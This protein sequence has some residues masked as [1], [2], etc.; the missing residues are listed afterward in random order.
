MS[1]F[2]ALRGMD[3]ARQRRVALAA[4]LGAVA[5]SMLAILFWS[6][7]EWFYADDWTYFVSRRSWDFHTLF[8]P[9]VGHLIVLPLVLFKVLL[10]IFGATSAVPF[11][12]AALLFV[13]LNGVLVYLLARRRLDPWLALVPAVLMLLLG[14]GWEMIIAPFALNALMSI[15]AGLGMLLFLDRGDRAGD[16]GACLLLIASLA[17]FSLGIVFGVIA[18]VELWQRPGW[19]RRQGWVY[20]L[21]AAVYGV[22]LIWASQ[23]HQNQLAATNIGPGPTAVAQGA[24]AVASSAF[25]VFRFPGPANPAAPDLGIQIDWGIPIAL[26]L[27][28]VLVLRLRAA[29]PPT[30]RAWAL[31]VA[32]LVLWGLLALSI[33]PAR[34]PVASRYVYPGVLLA[35]LLAIELAAPLA[36]STGWRI[37]IAAA[38]GIS[39]LAN[40]D[41]IRV[42]GGYFRAEAGY[43]RSELAAL[44]LARGRVSDDFVVE[45][46]S[47]NL[48]PH[49]DMLFSA[50]DYF[51]AVDQYGSPA[52]SLSQLAAASPEQRAAADQELARALELAARPTRSPVLKAA[53]PGQVQPLAESPIDLGSGAN[54]AIKTPKPG[55]ALLQPIAGQSARV[56]LRLPPQ[57]FRYGVGRDAEMKLAL[58]RFGDGF[59][60]KLAPVIGPAVV[61]IPKDGSRRPWH[62]LIRSSQPFIA[63]PA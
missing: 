56:A 37:A 27:G 28:A 5:I 48:L 29:P 40:V 61:S 43:N 59:A 41:T 7:G 53:G 44:Q 3:E 21:P 52:Y 49:G 15:A 2:S 36:I 6:R 18:A 60:V 42:G 11:R 35:L 12:L 47:S 32:L 45:E 51:K 4:L 31:L 13:E 26:A 57:G 24:A 1:D 34:S 38:L 54:M 19:G 14:S 39:L 46:G 33:G 62:V 30:A 16:A 8:Y 58:G 17:S 10:E 50:G 23:F 22:W 9:T 63:C 55:C 20:L 25:G